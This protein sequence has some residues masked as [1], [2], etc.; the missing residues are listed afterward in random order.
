MSS[1]N[2]RLKREHLVV[3]MSNVQQSPASTQTAKRMK[4]VYD[5]EPLSTL[6]KWYLDSETADVHFVFGSSDSDASSSK[7]VPAHKILLANH[8]EEF[9]AMLYG[10]MKK[11]GDIRM[12]DVSKAAFEEFLQFFYLTEVELSVENF[13]DIMHLGYKYM[14]TNCIEVCVKFFKDIHYVD[15][16]WTGLE[17]GIRYN[18]LK[19]VTFCERFIAGN[20][21]AVL[22]SDGFLGCDRKLLAHILDANLFVCSEVAMFKACMAWVMVKSGHNV[23]TKEA[24]DEHLGDLFYS[25]RFGS[26]T[27]GEFCQLLEKYDAVL[28]DDAKTI[29]KLIGLTGFHQDR[30]STQSRRIK[31]TDPN[32]AIIECDR[33][34]NDSESGDW[35][36]S[37]STTAITFSANKRLLLTGFTINKIAGSD[38]KGFNVGLKI[39]NVLGNHRDVVLKMTAK[40]QSNVSTKISLPRPILVRAGLMYTFCEISIELPGVPFAFSYYSKELKEEVMLDPDTLIRFGECEKKSNDTKVVGIISELVFN[41]V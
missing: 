32:D 2:K 26:M 33:V 23:L 15:N 9:K 4:K 6:E 8:S 14:V 18:H 40:V 28:S 21:N 22:K 3:E 25:I 5:I 13:A 36:Q 27:I 39:T 35:F 34:V 10:A 29:T 1:V 20:T 37:N 31:W 12:A 19:L 38:A 7:R 11:S 17:L 16:I 24:V 30:F 41:R